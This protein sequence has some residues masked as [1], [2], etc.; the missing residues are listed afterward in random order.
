MITRG[1]FQTSL[2][3]H[4]PIKSTIPWNNLEGN[5]WTYPQKSPIPW[6]TP[7]S[8]GLKFQF[9]DP[10]RY[11]SGK[12]WTVGFGKSPFFIGHSTKKITIFNG[13][14]GLR[15]VAKSPGR[16]SFFSMHA[17]KEV[18]DFNRMS[19]KMWLFSSWFMHVKPTMTHGSEMD[20]EDLDGFSKWISMKPMNNPAYGILRVTVR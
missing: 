18:R 2:Y 1:K 15:W 8:L 11:N 6:D 7:I 17:G 10:I 14:G 12:T 3:H 9:Q 19:G 13:S 16:C 20:L 5:R 4:I